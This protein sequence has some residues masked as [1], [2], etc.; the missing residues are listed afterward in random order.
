VRAMYDYKAKRENELSFVKD[1]I[2]INV[3]KHDDGWWQG[4]LGINKR[5]K[6]PSNFVE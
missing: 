1:S 4:D 6:F 3:K 5:L 2:I